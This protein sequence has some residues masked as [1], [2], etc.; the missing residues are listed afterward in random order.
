MSHNISTVEKG[1]RSYL[2]SSISL[3]TGNGGYKTP[4][5]ILHQEDNEINGL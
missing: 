2:N 4:A 3:V 5:F 1:E